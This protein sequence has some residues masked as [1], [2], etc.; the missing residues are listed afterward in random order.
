MQALFMNSPMQQTFL[1]DLTYARYYPIIVPSDSSVNKTDKGYLSG[2]ED[3]KPI[4]KNISCA[5]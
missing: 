5:K 3:K 2:D 1:E 4:N